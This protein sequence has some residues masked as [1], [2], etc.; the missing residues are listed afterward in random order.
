[1]PSLASEHLDCENRQADFS[2]MDQSRSIANIS[3]IDLLMHEAEP[4]DCEN[5]TYRC[6]LHK[7]KPLDGDN[8][9]HR[10]SDMD[11]RLLIANISH[12]GFHA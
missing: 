11:Q 2:G 9:A 5:L 3:H 4:L 1:M 8:L 6:L 12:I 10:F 7:P